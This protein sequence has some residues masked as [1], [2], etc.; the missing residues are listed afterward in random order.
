MNSSYQNTNQRAQDGF[1]L[2]VAARL[3]DA[4]NSLPYDI[5]ERLRA[6]RAQALG[7]RKM[8]VIRTATSLVA[9]GGVATLTGGHEHFGWW[10]RIAAVAPLLA[11]IFGL[12]AINIIQNDIRANE[13]AEV[14]SALLTDA[15]PPEA[16]AD[17]GFTQFLKMS[18]TENQQ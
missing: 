9:S 13:L 11:L 8:T 6:A 4:S 14:D 3:S 17:P 5:S 2:A 15:L 10:G 12:I 1:G 18:F 7:K 16:Y